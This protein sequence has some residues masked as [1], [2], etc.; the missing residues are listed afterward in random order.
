MTA[1]RLFQQAFSAVIDRRYN[2]LD[3][4]RITRAVYPV[5]RRSPF[6]FPAGL[7]LAIFAHRSLQSRNGATAGSALDHNGKL[8]VAAHFSGTFSLGRCAHELLGP[9]RVRLFA[10]WFCR[11]CSS[12]FARRQTDPLG[13]NFPRA[14]LHSESRP[15]SFPHPGCGRASSLRLLANLARLANDRPGFFVARLRG[16]SRLNG[17]R[18]AGARL[19][20]HLFCRCPLAAQ[21]RPAFIRVRSPLRIYFSA[22]YTPARRSPALLLHFARRHS[23]F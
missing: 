19:L 2:N 6:C 4:C 23:G 11:R 5:Y 15:R 14:L 3:R 17:G 18:R 21:I 7:A 10:R 20:L 22:A 1:E 16:Y 13:T 12:R 8:R 9:E